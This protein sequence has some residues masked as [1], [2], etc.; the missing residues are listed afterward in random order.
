MTV[1]HPKITNS[2]YLDLGLSLCPSASDSARIGDSRP[3]VLKEKFKQEKLELC[4]SNA[5]RYER[6]MLMQMSCCDALTNT[7]NHSSSDRRQFENSWY[8]NIVLVQR[9]EKTT[10]TSRIVFFVFL[11]LCLFLSHSPLVLLFSHASLKK[12]LWALYKARKNVSLLLFP[13]TTLCSRSPHVNNFAHNFCPT[14]TWR[15]R[16]SKH[17]GIRRSRKERKAQREFL[18]IFLTMKSH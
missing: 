1:T 14:N 11:L 13:Y 7:Q 8:I 16:E 18:L 10:R 12:G 3:S 15:E 9:K 4:N 2:P 6:S 5:C 17:C